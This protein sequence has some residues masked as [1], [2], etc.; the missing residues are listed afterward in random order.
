MTALSAAASVWIVVL[1]CNRMGISIMVLAIALVLSVVITRGPSVIYSTLALSVP[2]GLSML[3]VHGLF[4]PDPIPSFPL[5]KAAGTLRAA[6]LTVRLAALMAAT[7]TAFSAFKITEL[8]KALQQRLRPQLAY[9]MGASV[10]LLPQAQ[11]CIR[12]VHEAQF[13]R[14]STST[15][16]SVVPVMIQV[17]DSAA[18]RGHALEVAGID[19]PGPRSVA[20]P[21][22]DSLVQKAARFLMPILAVAAV[23]IAWI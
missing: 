18:R 17:M 16:R 1:G 3:M 10:Q 7:L 22:Y 14:G 21:A 2:A 8:A 20:R 9:I 23:V 12:N 19:L 5:F 13:L 11:R 15:W 6:E 4:G